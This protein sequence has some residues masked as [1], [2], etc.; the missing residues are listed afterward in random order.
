MNERNKSFH[1][2][3]IQPHKQFKITF[4]RLKINKYTK[5]LVGI[6]NNKLTNSNL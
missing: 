2:T 4:T 6:Q 5:Y 3:L 1:L